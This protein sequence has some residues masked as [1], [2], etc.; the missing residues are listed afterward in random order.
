MIFIQSFLISDISF[1]PQQFKL[2]FILEHSIHNLSGYLMLLSF[3]D[4]FFNFK[5]TMGQTI[6]NIEGFIVEIETCRGLIFLK[7][8][9]IVGF[10]IWF[11]LLDYFVFKVRKEVNTHII[12]HLCDPIGSLITSWGKIYLNNP[13]VER[14]IQDKIKAINLKSIGA[15]FHRILHSFE[16]SIYYIL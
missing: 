4:A 9:F 8:V 12:K 3:K 15:L 7:S 2:Y 11:I 13:R 1:H 16:G 14:F 6:L 10:P 5:P